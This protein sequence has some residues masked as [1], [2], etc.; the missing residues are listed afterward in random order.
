MAWLILYKSD[1]QLVI[2][3]KAKLFRQGRDIEIA[4]KVYNKHKKIV[5][6]IYFVLSGAGVGFSVVFLVNGDN[7]LPVSVIVSLVFLSLGFWGRSRSF[8]AADRELGGNDA[9]KPEC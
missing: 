4:E 6:T 7:L 2:Y 5:S 1:Q 9:S 8:L 3:L